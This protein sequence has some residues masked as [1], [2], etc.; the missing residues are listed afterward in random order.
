MLLKRKADRIKKQ[1]TADPEKGGTKVV[2]TVYQIQKGDVKWKDF[3]LHALCR[4]FVLFAQ[5]PIIQLFGVYLAFVYGVVYCTSPPPY[6]QIT[7]DIV[8]PVVLTTI[9]SV[10][11]DVYHERIGI[12]G[13]HYISLVS[14]H[15]LS[16]G[17][18]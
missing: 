9:P 17:G 1:L 13:L 14:H 5:E 11:T 18:F 16:Y 12:V 6:R 8:Y 10:Y 4:P 15:P 3:L 7:S 2:K